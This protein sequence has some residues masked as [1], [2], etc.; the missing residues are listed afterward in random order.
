MPT[1]RGGCS[2]V[3]RVAKSDARGRA[4]A[5][6]AWRHRQP[7]D[8][9]CG[10]A[11]ALRTYSGGGRSVGGRCR[12]AAGLPPT[13]PASQGR[14]RLARHRGKARSR[15]WRVCAGGRR[16]R[17]RHL[18]GTPFEP[19]ARARGTRWE[20]QRGL[21][22]TA[23]RARQA[24][25]HVATRVRL[26]QPPPATARHHPPPPVGGRRATPAA[27]TAARR[28]SV[29]AAGGSPPHGGGVP[30]ARV[31]GVARPPPAI[32]RGAPARRSAAADTPAGWRP[33]THTASRWR[34]PS[35]ASARAP[36]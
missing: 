22:A 14:R 21:P 2:R 33:A 4:S 3:R 9:R 24:D 6:R 25:V 23:A 12:R 28:Y 34:P 13:S 7:L 36:D 20:A 8:R 35:M 11:R 15:S 30:P 27:A 32:V 19:P 5:A 18:P 31:A 29:V 17:G 10:V 1:R 16:R 26:R